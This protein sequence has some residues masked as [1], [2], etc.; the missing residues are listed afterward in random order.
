M[1][2]RTRISGVAHHVLINLLINLPFRPEIAIDFIVADH[3]KQSH[4][5]L[6]NM[7]AAGTL[8][9]TSSYDGSSRA[10]ATTHNTQHQRARFLNAFGECA[11]SPWVLI[12]KSGDFSVEFDEGGGLKNRRLARRKIAIRQVLAILSR[13]SRC[14]ASRHNHCTICCTGRRTAL[15]QTVGASGHSDLANQKPLGKR[16][17]IWTPGTILNFGSRTNRMSKRLIDSVRFGGSATPGRIYD[18]RTTA[19]T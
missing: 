3:E 15:R 14:V 16:V 9:K 19:E 1:A 10:N 8:P 13:V 17:Q 4:C 2:V 12:A 18:H 6:A 11:Q 5:C 7:G